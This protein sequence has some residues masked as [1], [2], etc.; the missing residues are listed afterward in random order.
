MARFWEIPSDI[1]ITAWQVVIRNDW[2]TAFE[3]ADLP[4]WW[5]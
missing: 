3:W 5:W 1:A 4:E 2:V